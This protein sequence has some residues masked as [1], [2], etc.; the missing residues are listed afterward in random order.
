MLGALLAADLLLFERRHVERDEGRSARRGREPGTARYC[1]LQH[2]AFFNR[3]ADAKGLR[4]FA[5]DH[6]QRGATTGRARQH[7]LKLKTAGQRGLLR[8]GR[9]NGTQQPRDDLRVND[10]RL[11]CHW[12]RRDI[13]PAPF[14][15]SQTPI[16]DAR[17]SQRP[18]QQ[19]HSWQAKFGS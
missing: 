9:V 6:N 5:V 1:R 11:R 12:R 15:Q 19:R 10:W 2:Q 13:R 8:R 17:R 7:A 4:R 16:H 3:A 18:D 14:S